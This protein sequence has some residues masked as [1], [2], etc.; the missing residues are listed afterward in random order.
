MALKYNGVQPTAI[1]YNGTDLTVL[2]YGTTAVWGKPYSLTVIQGTGT[3]VL[4]TRTS[5]PNQQATTGALSSGATVYYGDILK[6]SVAVDSG[7]TLSSFT[8]N[9]IDGTATT[10]TAEVSGTVKVITSANSTGSWHTVWSGSETQSSITLRGGGATSTQTFSLSGLTSGATTRVTGTASAT[11]DGTTTS[12]SF[13][14]K[15]VTSSNTLVHE[16]TS[17]ISSTGCYVKV[18]GTTVYAYFELDS[19]SLSLIEGSGS[20][21]ITKVEQYY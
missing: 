5:S 1:K 18:V 19:T 8:I 14:Q 6:I 21:T 12:S 2:K 4:V 20:V 9:G 3:T 16:T 13:S 15:S 7:Y 17:G 10:R 11:C